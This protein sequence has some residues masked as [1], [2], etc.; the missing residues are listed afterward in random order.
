MS[1]QKCPIC[2]GHGNNPFITVGSSSS[3]PCPTC[4][5]T[6]IINEIT[7]QPPIKEEKHS[8][9]EPLANP[10]NA[11]AQN[12]FICNLRVLKPDQVINLNPDSNE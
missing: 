1:W 8:I 9:F 12:A 7:G 4:K 5:G 6:R 2:E 10:C 11:D 3:Y